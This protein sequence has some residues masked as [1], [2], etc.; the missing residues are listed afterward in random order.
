MKCLVVSQKGL[1]DG[2]ISLILSNNLYLNNNETLTFNDGKLKELQGWFSH[3]PI[4]NF[5]DISRVLS[6][7][8]TFDKIFVFYD[9]SDLFIQALI[10]EGKKNYPDKIKVIHPS[11]SKSNGKQLYYEDALFRRDISMADNLENFCKDILK[12]EKVTKDN[13]IS[14]PNDLISRKYERRII[15]HPTSAKEGRS[16]PRK[17][18]LK[19]YLMLKKEGLDPCFVMSSMEEKLWRKEAS[20]FFKIKG[21]ENYDCLASY[22]F[23]SGYFIGNDSGVGHLASS[24]NLPVLCISRSKRTIDLWRPGWGRVEVIYPYNFIPNIGGFRLRDKKWKYFISVKRVFRKFIKK[25]FSS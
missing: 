5:P 21:F 2:L 13:G 10:N 3:L 8:Q 16:W 25:L 11:F 1:G 22:V 9:S 17:K 24:L 23:E 14:S 19:L 15:L 12:L 7:Y 4:E 20:D 6:I 18:F